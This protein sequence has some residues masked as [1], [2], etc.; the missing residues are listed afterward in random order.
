MWQRAASGASG[1]GIDI[2][3]IIN[4]RYF[5]YVRGMASDPQASAL[6][7]VGINTIEFEARSGYPLKIWGKEDKTNLLYTVNG[8]QTVDVSAYNVIFLGMDNGYSVS[9][10]YYTVKS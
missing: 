2:S 5:Q 9:D 1:G 8:T 10:L 4:K 7:V 3:D 6:Y